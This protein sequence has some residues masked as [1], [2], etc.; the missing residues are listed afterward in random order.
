MTPQKDGGNVSMSAARPR[1]HSTSARQ[2]HSFAQR[3]DPR[4]TDTP[5]ARSS[6]HHSSRVSSCQIQ[7]A[8][9]KSYSMPGFNLTEAAA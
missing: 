8:G 4:A 3:F 1:N 9:E 2:S 5:P 7:K 6:H